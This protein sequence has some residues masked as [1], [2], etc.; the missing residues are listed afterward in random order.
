MTLAREKCVACRRDSPRVTPEDIADLHPIVT[1]WELTES[2]RDQAT[3]PDIQVLGLRRGLGVLPEG[4]RDSRGR[5][6]SPPH[7]HRMGPRERRVVDAQDTWSAP[8]RLHHGREDRRALRV[9]RLSV[10]R[11][12]TRL[13]P[14]IKLRPRDCRGFHVR[15]PFRRVGEKQIGPHAHPHRLE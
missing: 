11:H 15:Q 6:T 1:D 5:G 10:R 3:R 14:T 4:R 12:D 2:R 9:G 7:H 8:Q 13:G